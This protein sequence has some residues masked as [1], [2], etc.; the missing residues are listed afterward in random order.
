MFQY[1]FMR[2]AFTAGIFIALICSVIGVFVI[3][4]QTSFFTHTLSEIGF[5]GASFGVFAGISPFAGML[6]FTCCS[7]LFIGLS[8]E[9]VS[10]RESSISVFSGLF[11]GLGILFLSLSDKQANYA[12]SILFGSIV[13][14]DANELKDLV[15]LSIFLLILIFFT[16]RKLAYSSFDAQGAEYNQRFNKLI[17]ILF[18]LMLALTVSITAQ[19]IGALLIFVLLTIPASASKYYVHSL[20]KMIGLTFVFALTGVWLGLYLSYLTDWPVSFFITA[21]E[22]LIYGSA[23]LKQR[24]AERH[25]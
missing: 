1:A 19:I 11:L 18:L 23:I 25:K 7:A 10:R 9:K 5:S 4:R 3:A 21:I 24:I 6:L 8:G 13:G 22:A 16:F 14:I 2:Y 20:W 12:T 15:C 17:S